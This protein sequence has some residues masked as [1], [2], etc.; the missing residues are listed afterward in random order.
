MGSPDRRLEIYCQRKR[1]CK[2]IEEEQEFNFCRTSINPIFKLAN[3]G[4]N[5]LSS[6]NEK[7][8]YFKGTP[9]YIV[10]LN[11]T[12]RNFATDN[13]YKTVN[14]LNVTSQQIFVKPFNFLFGLSTPILKGSIHE[15]NYLKDTGMYIFFEQNAAVEFCKTFRRKIKLYDRG[16]LIFKPLI[17][18]PKILVY[19][20]E[21][22]LESWEEKLIE[23]PDIKVKNNLING[24]HNVFDSTLIKFIPSKDSIIDLENFLQ[25]PKKSFF[26]NSKKF[27]NFKVRCLTG[28]LRTIL[29]TN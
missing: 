22:F 23:K 8:R 4:K 5:N 15:K 20:L 13:Y 14:I 12:E 29:N 24:S 25:Q 18:K 19:N 11:D 6:L 10:K 26:Q 1:R 2:P 17:K 7:I 3:I 28:F 21:D 9:I 27:I 16:H